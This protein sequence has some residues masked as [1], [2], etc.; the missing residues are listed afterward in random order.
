MAAAFV[1]PIPSVATVT[2][3]VTVAVAVDVVVVTVVEVVSVADVAVA[4]VVVVVE[5]VVVEVAVVVVID[6]V[7]EVAVVV[8]AHV[9]VRASKFSYPSAQTPIK[10]SV[11]AVP[12]QALHCSTDMTL[13]MLLHAAATSSLPTR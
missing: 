9:P 6:A 11:A 10:Q 12:E 1:T 3:E 4:V 5:T 8:L 7:V 13:S 2:D